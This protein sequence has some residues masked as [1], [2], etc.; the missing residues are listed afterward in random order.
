MIRYDVT[1]LGLPVQRLAVCDHPSLARLRSCGP[2]RAHKG[3][4]G[5][6]LLELVVPGRTAQDWQPWAVGVDGVAMQIAGNAALAPLRR[7]PVPSEAVW[8]DWV[9]GVRGPVLPAYC[10]GLDVDL[11]GTV[12]PSGPGQYWAALRR[13]ADLGTGASWADSLPVAQA[14]IESCHRCPIELA[15]HLRLHT[16]TDIVKL[17]QLAAGDTGPK[18]G[19]AA[20]SSSCGSP[21]STGA[22]AP[23]PRSDGSPSA[24]PPDSGSRSESGQQGHADGSHAEEHGGSGQ[25]ASQ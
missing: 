24:P 9:C 21:A 7:N 8:H 19:S 14:A 17:V 23:C 16:T 10:E 6:M 15:R 1:A 18:G 22:D 3:E 13:L 25:E 20:A 4:D 12:R 11:D 2:W 5:R